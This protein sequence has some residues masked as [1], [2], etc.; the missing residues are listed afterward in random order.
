[1]DRPFIIAPG[2][3]EIPW[4]I[5]YSEARLNEGAGVAIRDIVSML[6]QITGHR[7]AIRVNPKFV[8]PD[9]PRRRPHIDVGTVVEIPNHKLKWD[10]SNPTGH[11]VL[12][13]SRAGYVYCFVQPGGV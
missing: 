11:G 12:F 10:K 3:I 13:L 2:D 1:M 5:H 4:C 9:E 6:E 8:R 7:I